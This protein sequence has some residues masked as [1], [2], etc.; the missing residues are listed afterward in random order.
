MHI[1]LDFVFS[2]KSSEKLLLSG[3]NYKSL[4]INMYNIHWK[5]VQVKHF[6]APQKIPIFQ[7]SRSAN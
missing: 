3:K 5:M 7:F 1:L 4:A 6:T 2:A